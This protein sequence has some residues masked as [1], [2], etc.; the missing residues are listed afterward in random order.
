MQGEHV[1]LRQQVIEVP[2]PGFGGATRAIRDLDLHAECAGYSGHRLPESA[3]ADDSED[4]PLQ[5]PDRVGEHRELPGLLPAAARDE[6]VVIREAVRERKQ[7]GE[8]MLRDRSGAVVPQVADR[9]AGFARGRKIDV[10]DAGR[11]ECDQPELWIGRDD[12][13]VDDGL[14][15]ENSLATGNA[16]GNVGL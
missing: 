8:D 16:G 1:E 6:S 15:R 3:V 12:R 11:G 13:A 5:F 10:V 14:V 4:P 7:H 2:A 9:D